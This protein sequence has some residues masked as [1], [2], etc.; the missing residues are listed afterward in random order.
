MNKNILTLLACSG[1][2]IATISTPSY[3]IMRPG[4]NDGLS[5]SN[6]SP[7]SGVSGQEENRYSNPSAEESPQQSQP[8][9]QSMEMRFQ[10][11]SQ[12]TFGCGCANCLTATKKMLKEGSLS[13]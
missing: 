10:Q 13:L 9:K 8:A 11:L 6:S 3:A 4:T 12:Q 7:V 5:S 2:L 1:S